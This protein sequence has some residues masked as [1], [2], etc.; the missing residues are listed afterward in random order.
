M[1]TAI[2]RKTKKTVVQKINCTV[3]LHIQKNRIFVSY[4]NRTLFDAILL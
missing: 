3:A 4:L 1:T 2:L